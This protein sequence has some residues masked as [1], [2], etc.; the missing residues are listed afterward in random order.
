MS[1]KNGD[2]DS[3]QDAIYEAFKKMRDSGIDSSG[4]KDS[5]KIL[6][7]LSVDLR[8]AIVNYVDSITVT[9]TGT[10]VTGKA[11]EIVKSTS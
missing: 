4:V 11:G 3:L 9:V 2:I 1:I 10:L 6:N 7:D 8:R 5:E